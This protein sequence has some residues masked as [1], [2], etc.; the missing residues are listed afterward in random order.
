MRHTVLVKKCSADET[1][2]TG[3]PKRDDASPSSTKFVHYRN[4]EN[5]GRNL[6][7]AGHER[8]EED[9]ATDEVDSQSQAVVD[10]TSDEPE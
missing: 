9:I 6:N 2:E 1:S 5:K 10:H 8:I 7:G 3:D 4:H